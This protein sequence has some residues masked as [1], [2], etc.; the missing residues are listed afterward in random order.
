MKFIVGIVVVFGLLCAASSSTAAFAQNSK[1]DPSLAAQVNQSK[2]VSAKLNTAQRNDVKELFATAFN[3]LKADELQAGKMAF[4][5]ALLIDPANALG[6]YYLAEL[7]SKLNDSGAMLHYTLTKELAPDSKEAFLADVRLAKLRSPVAGG[8]IRDCSECPELVGIPKG[9]FTMGA[10]Q[11][12]RVTGTQGVST[13]AIFDLSLPQQNITINRTLAVGRYEVTFAQWDACVSAGGCNYK[14]DDHGWGRADRPVINVS[15]DDVT[16]QYLPWLNRVSGVD[17]RPQ[18]E[19]YRLLTEAEWEYVARAGC[20]T[21]FSVNGDCK[22][23]ISTAEANFV[24]NI[25][26]NGTCMS[27]RGRTIPIGS[28]NAPNKWGLHDMHGNVW[29]WVEDCWVDNL[30]TMPTDGAARSSSCTDSGWHVLRGGSL[31]SIARNLRAASR[32]KYPANVRNSDGG[33]R[34]VRTVFP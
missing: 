2:V 27:G 19:H 22:D 5:R 18:Q 20:S 9:S 15:W 14:P 26:C 16:R 4:E 21:A 32:N 24:G 34:V 28:L 8:I 31:D 33:F 10:P 13:N 12:E 29:E 7:L 11:S 23:S 25:G 30:R 6:H 3:L 17:R 1:D